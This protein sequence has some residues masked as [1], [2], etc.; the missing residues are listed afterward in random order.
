MNAYKHLCASILLKDFQILSCN[1]TGESVYYTGAV[2]PGV[3]PFVSE[4]RTVCCISGVFY[5]V[6]A[7]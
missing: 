7:A 2:I 4:V 3:H 1:K 6:T 5:S